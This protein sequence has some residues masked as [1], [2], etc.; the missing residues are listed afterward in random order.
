MIWA[1][2]LLA[3]FFLIRKENVSGQLF[4]CPENVS[5]YLNLNYTCENEEPLFLSC[6]EIPLRIADGLY[7]TQND[8]EGEYLHLLYK[9]VIVRSP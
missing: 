5:L 9:R 2:I 6:D 3:G 1:K 7:T 8:T 4:C